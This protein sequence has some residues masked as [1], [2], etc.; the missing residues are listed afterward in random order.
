MKML[1]LKAVT[2]LAVT[3]S[4]VALPVANAD[5]SVNTHKGCHPAKYK[6]HYTITSAQKAPRITHIRTYAMPPSS[7]HKVTKSASYY[8]RLSASVRVGAGA[9][10]SS[11]GISRVL[12]KASARVNMALKA[13]GTKTSTHSE[14]VTDWIKNQTHHNVQF[15]FYKGWTKAWGSF[16]HYYCDEYYIDGQNYGPWFVTYDAGKWQSYNIPGN[17]AVSCASDV[18]YLGALARAAYRIGCKA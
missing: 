15:V 12:G 18:R 6:A 8:S 1:I 16:R 9:S 3:A 10:I 4:V 7:R 13:A 17:G 11:S 5:A 14:S 2:T